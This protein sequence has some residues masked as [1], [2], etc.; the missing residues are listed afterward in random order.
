MID[1]DL[2]AFGFV[3]KYQLSN[4]VVDDFYSDGVH[5]SELTYKFWAQEIYNFTI[6]KQL[7]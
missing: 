3:D 2:T 6:Q 7:I 4:K 5:P 1:D